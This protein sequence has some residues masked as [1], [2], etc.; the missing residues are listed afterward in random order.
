MSHSINQNTSTKTKK[1]LLRALAFIMCL[2]VGVA[3][4][5]LRPFGGKQVPHY[6]EDSVQVVLVLD[7]NHVI[8]L[9]E[10]IPTYPSGFFRRADSTLECRILQQP[11]C[12]ERCS[13]D[14]VRSALAE[15]RQS[16]EERLSQLDQLE[17]ELKY[18]ERTHT[19]VD[20]SYNQV[21]D[22]STIIHSERDSLKTLDGY[23]ALTETSEDWYV[24]TRHRPSF[25]ALPYC[26]D[27]FPMLQVLPMDSDGFMVRSHVE[28]DTLL[29]GTRWRFE[30][31]N[32]FGPQ[33]VERYEGDL[34]SLL[35]PSG[36]GVC[37]GRSYYEGE[38]SE[39]MRQGFGI[40]LVPGRIIG[41]GMWKNN[42]FFGE[43]ILHHE[44]RVYGIDISRYQHE[45]GKRKYPIHWKG[46]R[47]ISLGVR[48]PKNIDGR[49]D[50]PLTFCYIKASQG[51]KTQ[52]AYSTEDAFQARM[53]GVHVGHYH[54]FSPIDGESQAHWF[55][56]NASLR[57]GDMPPMLDVELNDK[58]IASMGGAER[59]LQEM[60]RWVR[61][62][63]ERCHTTPVLY[64]NQNFVDNY[65]VDAPAELRECPVWVARYSQF[66]PY[67]RLVFWQ[68]SDDGNVRGITG[69]V[70]IDVFNGSIEQFND[71][72][73]ENCIK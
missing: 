12:V 59:M 46:T 52:S 6:V 38:W 30:I 19:V 27:S 58:Q 31:K 45:K 9:S 44:N 66:R 20:E 48:T 34:D 17:D 15:M 54:F 16:I 8:P 10:W 33:L 37:V 55:L 64:V 21:M 28:C 7:S 29:R 69:K 42:K 40:G 18:Y 73:R 4:L 26:L 47:I 24:E 57:K 53:A 39:G 22:L 25:I 62:V 36:E 61:V 35:R 51:V 56:Q 72:L 1:H 14:S 65:L 50:Y 71:F 3:L 63:K 67:V 32:C 2:G 13:D 11:I 68:L 43:K 70:D 5:A 41:V 23:L 49:A 60:V